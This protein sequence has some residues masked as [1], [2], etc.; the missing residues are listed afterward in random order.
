MKDLSQTFNTTHASFKAKMREA[1][2]QKEPSMKSL[3]DWQKIKSDVLKEVH[4]KFGIKPA[5][6]Y[7]GPGELHSFFTKP[8]T[9]EVRAAW[10]R[11]SSRYR[12]N[13][14]VN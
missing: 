5:D 3:N 13:F 6:V 8:V 1:G 9:D 11:M 7:P 2:N 12:N 10:Y 4:R 14:N